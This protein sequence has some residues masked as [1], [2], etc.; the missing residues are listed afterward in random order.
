MAPFEVCEYPIWK[1][2]LLIIQHA[3]DESESISLKKLW[4]DDRKPIQY[5]AFWVAVVVLVLT[6]TFGILQSICSLIQAYA[7]M[8][9]LNKSY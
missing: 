8:K 6:V 9:A 4:M 5:Y 7:S 1:D 2:R 3:F